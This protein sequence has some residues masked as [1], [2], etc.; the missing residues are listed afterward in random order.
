MTI[1]GAN[2]GTA[3]GTVVTATVQGHPCK[4]TEWVSDSEVKCEV[5]PG[6]S[7]HR[8]VPRMKWLSSL[9]LD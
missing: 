4:R 2:L 1:L 5:P 8:K 6:F 3:P 7:V 9:N